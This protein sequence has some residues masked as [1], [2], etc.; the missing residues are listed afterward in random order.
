MGQSSHGLYSLNHAPN[1]KDFQKWSDLASD[2]TAMQK[3]AITWYA[4]QK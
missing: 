4:Q 2:T 3:E 1:N